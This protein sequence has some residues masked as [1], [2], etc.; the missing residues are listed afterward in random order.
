MPNE[1]DQRTIVLAKR[2]TKTERLVTDF[3]SICSS[4]AAIGCTI[5][6]DGIKRKRGWMLHPS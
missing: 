5:R 1:T 4:V 3:A 2:K 6:N